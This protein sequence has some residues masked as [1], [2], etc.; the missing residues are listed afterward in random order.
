MSMNKLYIFVEGN[1]DS[2]FFK[3][4]FKPIFND[5]YDDVEIIQFAQLKKAKVDLFIMSINTLKFDYF[6]VADIDQ[7]D[8]ITTKKK[9]IRAKFDKIDSNQI[10]IV[11]S[12]IESWFLAGMTAESAANLGLDLIERTDEVTKEDFNA[13]FIRTYRS[14]IDFMQEVLKNYSIE[15]ARKRNKSFDY[16]FRQYVLENHALRNK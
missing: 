12:E 3:T 16:F 10:V 6:L 8:T 15:T 7:C 5:Y 14:R 9:I 4:L 2:L 13:Y 11:I 1:D